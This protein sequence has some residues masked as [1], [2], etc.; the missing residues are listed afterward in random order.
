M[1]LR[2]VGPPGEAACR[3]GQHPPL[4]PI[5]NSATFRHGGAS[6]CAMDDQNDS[7]V[8]KGTHAQPYVP[9]GA[10]AAEGGAAVRKGV[11]WN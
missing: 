4:I 2:K 10:D 7:L 11:E 8:L 6:Q 1:A 3:G 5:R 9:A